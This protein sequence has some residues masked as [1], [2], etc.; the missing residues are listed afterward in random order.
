MS[1]HSDTCNCPNCGKD[2][3]QYTDWKPYSYSSIECFHCGLHIYPHI[4]YYTLEELNERR[5]DRD[6]DLEPLTELPEQDKYF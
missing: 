5:L 6:D 3:D 2:A 1:G 4:E